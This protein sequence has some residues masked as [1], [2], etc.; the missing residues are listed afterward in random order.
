MSDSTALGDAH[1][2]LRP[3][4]TK[5][6]AFGFFSHRSQT[7]APDPRAEPLSMAT[8]ELASSAEPYAT[9]PVPLPLSA[10][11]STHFVF[12]AWFMCSCNC[13]QFT[14]DGKSPIQ[15]F[16]ELGK[17]LIPLP[18]PLPLPQSPP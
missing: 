11:T 14:S 10:Y 7:M 2:E 15:T 3:R 16:T 4:G 18:L 5:L 8:A 9:Q 1:S 6:H 13:F 17:L 12:P